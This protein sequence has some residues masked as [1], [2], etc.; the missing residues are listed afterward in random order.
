MKALV[1]PADGIGDALL[2]MIAAQQLVKKGFNVT[3]YHKEFGSFKEW[4]P[5]VKIEAYDPSKIH[6]FDRV[7]LQNDDS[8][9]ALQ[10]K[11]IRLINKQIEFSIFYPRYK[12]I[13]HGYLEKGDFVFDPRHTMVKNIA[14]SSQEL[15]SLKTLDT[16]TGI[17]IP[18]NLSYQ[19][20]KNRVLIH[21]TS[22][23]I[24][25]NWLQ[26][27]YLKLA[28][29]LI[30]N[31]FDPQIICSTQ[32]RPI[33]KFFEKKGLP[34]S[35]FETLSEAAGYIYE[36][37]HLIGN[38]SLIGHLASLLQ[39]PTTIIAKEKKHMRLWRPGWLK[40]SVV[41]PPPWVINCKG[42][43]LRDRYWKRFVFVSQVLDKFSS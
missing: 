4:F 26:K 36:S 17:A 31:G 12:F 30:K 19:K 7:I 43:R 14:K 2:M 33:C 1:I 25:K 9:K 35:S 20:N 15:L 8:E 13:K 11:Q 6:S 38:D 22:R 5:K 28:K 42:L 27:K 10:L 40:G 23:D 16:N 18:Q 34:I 37:G 29:K 41:T 39:I 24:D 21:P 32:E 3:L